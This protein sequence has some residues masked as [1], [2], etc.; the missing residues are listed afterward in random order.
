MQFCLYAREKGH[1]FWSQ[2][3][4]GFQPFPKFVLQLLHWSSTFDT[5]LETGRAEI[6]RRFAT[7]W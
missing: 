2:F 1:S 3:V 7:S 6:V 5:F 4:F